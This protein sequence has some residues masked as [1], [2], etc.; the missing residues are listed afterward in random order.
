MQRWLNIIQKAFPFFE[1]NT[2]NKDNLSFSILESVDEKSLKI[3]KTSEKGICFS[4]HDN[5]NSFLASIIEEEGSQVEEIQDKLEVIFDR[6]FENT[7]S[8]LYAA[9]NVI[10]DDM[11]GLEVLGGNNIDDSTYDVFYGLYLAGADKSYVIIGFGNDEVEN[12]FEKLTGLSRLFSRKPFPALISK[13][14]SDD[15]EIK[16]LRVL[17][18][19]LQP[20][21]N[22][23]WQ[24][25]NCTFYV[26]DGKLD[27]NQ[28]SS[29]LLLSK[30]GIEEMDFNELYNENKNIESDIALFLKAI[31]VYD[32]AGFTVTLFKDGRY[33]VTYYPYED[34]DYEEHD[35]SHDE[36]CT[37]EHYYEDEENDYF[38]TKGSEKEYALSYMNNLHSKI[39]SAVPEWDNGMVLIQNNE[40][41]T[42]VYPYYN[43]NSKP[44]TEINIIEN[45]SDDISDDE[46]MEEL[47]TEYGKYYPAMYD[48]FG[49]RVD[50][51][52][53]FTVLFN[54]KNNDNKVDEKSLVYKEFSFSYFT[55]VEE[56]GENNI[57]SS[58][59]SI[60]DEAEN[61]FIES[62]YCFISLIVE[63]I[64][65][66]IKIN[67]ITCYNTNLIAEEIKVDNN[68]SNVLK[69]IE[70]IYKETIITSEKIEFIIFPNGK[71]GILK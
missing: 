64:N 20:E 47:G 2:N 34:E 48:Y 26:K 18:N 6:L 35:H 52:N 53:L 33:G 13:G 43:K 22:L 49:D 39:L 16:A 14:K 27:N 70:N 62:P 50:D 57:D 36:S 63:K 42:M 67:N 69:N 68:F 5:E 37:H 38:P 71:I 58:L 9:R 44:Y 61:L 40:N 30:E 41:F 4:W 12:V 46:I 21:I 17:S 31:P 59:I 60:A 23:D 65:N 55:S 56:L 51:E 66:E 10:I 15:N 19:S 54:F 45:I 1:D 7:S 24:I 28:E 25:L 3:E 29:Y 8:E 32:I 11:F